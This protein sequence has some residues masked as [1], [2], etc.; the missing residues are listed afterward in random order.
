MF[1]SVANETQDSFEIH[2]SKV[3]KQGTSLQPPV[4][5]F[6]FFL[7][8]GA[9]VILAHL[10]FKAFDFPGEST[11]IFLASFIK[12]TQTS[13]NNLTAPVPL[14]GSQKYCRIQA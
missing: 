10:H 1:P 3:E 14:Y 11:D 9:D 13:S 8:L 2:L 5:L 6:F 4:V 7:E 12:D